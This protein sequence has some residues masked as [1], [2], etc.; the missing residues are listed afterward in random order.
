LA[1]PDW[2][3]AEDDVI[4]KV[5]EFLAEQGRRWSPNTVDRYRW[6]L[7]D[8]AKWLA[9]QKLMTPERADLVRWLDARMRWGSSSQYTAT[10]AA[11][12]FYR[13]L[14]GRENSPAE[15]LP[16]PKRSYRPQRVLDEAKVLRVLS[17][18][19]TSASK[20]RRDT[21]IILLMLDSGLRAAEVC[22]LRL[23]HL[24]LADRRFSVRIKGGR[25]ADGVFCAYTAS[26]LVEWI[27]DR[28]RTAV[29]EC[30]EVFCGVGGLTPGRKLTPSG[31]RVIF[32]EIGAK[33]GF[34]LSPHDLRRT[35]ATLAL[36]GGASSRLVQVAGRWSSLSEVE[37]Y[38]ASLTAADF[39]P[40]SPVAKVMGL[41]MDE[42]RR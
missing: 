27:T 31:L 18:L 1:P 2:P 24:D 29:G 41:R 32:R 21:A 36:K 16:L 22:R 28:G 42:S 14:L 12:G 37:R 6:Y 39:D 30:A 19:D 17:S 26:S 4:E 40:Y 15:G 3:A 34:H 23:E 20:G 38:S 25:W 7:L 11:R 9:G 13:W 8:L 5:D 10:T 35:F 33:A